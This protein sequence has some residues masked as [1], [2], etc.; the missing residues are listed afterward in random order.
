MEEKIEKKQ[1]EKKGSI[2]KEIFELLEDA[3][4]VLGLLCIVLTFVWRQVS[5]FGPSMQP[6]YY[7]GER[8]LITGQPGKLSTGDVVVIVNVL[9]EGPIIKRIIATEGQTV[10]FDLAAGNVIVDGETQDSMQFGVEN[11]ISFPYESRRFTPV[12]YPVQV[13]QGCVFVMGDN[14]VNSSD[15]RD[16]GVVDKRNVLGKAIWKF[17]PISEFGKAK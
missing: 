6:N 11:G 2:L 14:R 1:A 13:P 16:F 12:E 9:E 8:V 5:V 15:S 7:G 17:Y 3:V 4:M 10:D